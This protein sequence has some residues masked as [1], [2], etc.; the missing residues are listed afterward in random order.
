MK[1]SNHVIIKAIQHA[2][3]EQKKA[4]YIFF[5]DYFM[6]LMSEPLGRDLGE[7]IFNGINTDQHRLSFMA[8]AFGPTYQ[9]FRDGRVTGKRPFMSAKDWVTESRPSRAEVRNHT[10]YALNKI[11][12]R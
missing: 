10:K 11:L 7:L 5:R 9:L 8:V 4:M 12:T 3:V 2:N 1:Y 6:F